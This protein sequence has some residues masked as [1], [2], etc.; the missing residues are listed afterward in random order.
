MKKVNR[1]LALTIALLTGFAA[2]R[3]KLSVHVN[4]IRT[5]SSLVKI[6]DILS[7]ECERINAV[8]QRSKCFMSRIG[9]NLVELSA[10]LHVDERGLKTIARQLYQAFT[11]Q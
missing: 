4:H 1:P 8:G 2:Q 10:T 7:D 11:P 3:S 6:I 5:S 9:L